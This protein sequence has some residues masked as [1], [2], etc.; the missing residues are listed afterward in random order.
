MA[1][2]TRMLRH[3]CVLI[4]RA[5]SQTHTRPYFLHCH[6]S[7]DQPQFVKEQPPEC[8]QKCVR[9][10]HTCDKTKELSGAS[11]K[12]WMQHKISRPAS[13]K[14]THLVSR[15][16]NLS[17]VSRTL[18]SSS[19]T[20][21]M[22]PSCGSASHVCAV[23]C[24]QSHVVTQGRC[25]SHV[26]TQRR[27]K[28]HIV[29]Q[30]R[31]GMSV[32]PAAL[33][34]SGVDKATPLQIQ[35][36]LGLET[37]LSPQN[38]DVLQKDLSARGSGF[39]LD[40]LLTDYKHW[41]E[42]NEMKTCLERERTDIAKTMASLVKGKTLEDKMVEKEKLTARGKAIKEQMKETMPQWWSAEQKVMT[43][44]LMLPTELHPLTPHGED[45]TGDIWR[46]TV[47]DSGST[48][49]VQFAEQQGLLRF[50]TVGPRA[51]Y[52]LGEVAELEQS[53]L[54]NAATCVR[55]RGFSHVA[56]PEIFRTS[57]V[58]GCGLGP[59]KA[60][61]LQAKEEER[62]SNAYFLKGNSLLS[63]AALLTRIQ[64]RQEELPVRM[65]SIGRHYRPHA[66]DDLP[67][68]YGTV[69]SCRLTMFGAGR[70]GEGVMELH[71]A[72]VTATWDVVHTLGLPARKVTVSARKLAP[73]EGLRTEVQVWAPGLQRFVP[74]GF[75]SIHNDYTSR[76]LMTK[77]TNGD[78]LHMVS[79][80]AMD[81]A[82]VVASLL[83]HFCAQG[84]RPPLVRP[85]LT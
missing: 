52:L 54:H 39:N 19:D 33:F 62:E 49:H 40:Q 43:Q 69:Q 71:D 66:G 25:E 16:A 51:V 18:C 3:E 53:L 81:T 73:S 61:S 47:Q 34:S 29:P 44:A 75:V 65:S 38:L 32:M 77:A 27:Y 50:S 15:N 42:V 20:G 48:S 22:F 84:G 82:V 11:K 13:K 4:F 70:S 17:Q 23:A 9:H 41:K 7:P 1:L 37:K 35:A 26:L 59:E 36:N 57:V 85:D 24:T 58:E 83:E 74:M 10:L 5:A 78:L 2:I 14:I 31:C 28:S 60:L 67:G 64:V 55:N 80:V 12:K 72:M 21:S 45:Q 46:G 63:Y 6:K 8:Y 79:G 68:L 56:S 76:R 30:K